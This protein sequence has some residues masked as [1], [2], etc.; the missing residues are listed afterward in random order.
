[1][2][3]AGVGAGLMYFFDPNRGRTRRNRVRDKAKKLYKDGI[4]RVNHGVLDLENRA[5]GIAR[6]AEGE[7]RTF[8][9]HLAHLVVHG[10]LHLL[11]YDHLTDD[12]AQEMEALESRV[13]A[14]LGVA[15]PYAIDAA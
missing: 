12:E 14:K 6:E 9:D 8:D 2:L 7:S 1:M 13:L 11:G 10:L 4:A 3:A 5:L 15:D